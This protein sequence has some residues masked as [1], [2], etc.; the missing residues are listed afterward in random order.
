MSNIISNKFTIVKPVSVLRSA[1]VNKLFAIHS[2]A[3]NGHCFWN[4]QKQPFR[5]AQKDTSPKYYFKLQENVS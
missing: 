5:G 3:G 2:E 4:I 1:K